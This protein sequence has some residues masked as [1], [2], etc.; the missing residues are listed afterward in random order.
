MILTD[1]F[2]SEK[3]AAWDISRECGVRHGTIRLP[4]STDFNV[5]DEHHWQTVYDRFMNFGIEPIIIEP[6]PN[7]LHDHIKAGDS[8]RDE[9]IDRVIRMLPIMEKLDIRMICFNF[10]AHVGWT[11][12]ETDIEERGGARVTGFNLGHYLPRGARI[13]EEELWANYSYFLKAVVP[14][15]EKIE[16]EK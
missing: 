8:Q 9:S 4:E 14:E 16:N 3:D 12:T 2:R 13:T 7:D 11:R 6:M 5:T 10:M 15:A 1:Y